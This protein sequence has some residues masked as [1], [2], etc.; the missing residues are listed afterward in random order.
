MQHEIHKKQNGFT[1]V[2]LAIVLII[3]GLLIGG[4]LKGQELIANA[5]VNA[6][7]NEAKSFEAALAIFQDVYS[8]VPGDMINPATRVPNCAVGTV[9]GQVGDTN[10]RIGI[11]PGNAFPNLTN[12]NGAAWAQMLASDIITGV[13]QTAVLADPPIGGVSIPA[14]SVNGASWQIGH[15]VGGLTLQSGSL[16]SRSGHYLLLDNS[17]G[18]VASG[19]TASLSAS[20][21]Q[22]LDNKIDDGAPNTGTIR[23]MGGNANAVGDC[24]SNGTVAGIY[25]EF[26]QGEICGV[27]IRLQQ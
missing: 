18:A 10:G 9:C 25:R 1:L 12:E 6:V 11:G 2:E 17:L 26:E 22:R 3:I 15:T 21:A 23:A 8:T 19:A 20:Q 5:Q 27:Y 4:A 16:V 14:S 7:A 24:T 13:T